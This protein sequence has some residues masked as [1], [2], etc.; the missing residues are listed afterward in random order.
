MKGSLF[1]NIS[2]KIIR[3]LKKTFYYFCFIFTIK[4]NR[5]LCDNFCGNSFNDNPRYIVEA[6]LK[7][8]KKTDIYWALNKKTFNTYLPSKVK[9]VKYNSFKYFY[10]LATSKVWVDN[11]RMPFRIKKRTGQFYIQTWHGGFG[12]KRME[13]DLEKNF[14]SNYIRAAKF[15]SKNIDLLLTN[16]KWQQKYLKKCFY[17]DGEIMISGYPRCDSLFD[18]TRFDSIRNKVY[19][20]LNISKDTKVLLYAPTFRDD[21]DTKCYDIDYDRLI[22]NLEKKYSGDWKILIR[23]HPNISNLDQI[24]D[25]KNIINVTNYPVLNDLM[26]SSDILISDYSSLVFEYGYLSRPIILYVPDVLKYEKE[27]GLLFNFVDLPFPYAMNNDE[28]E[29]IIASYPD[30]D[31]IGNLKKFYKENGLKEDGHASE[32]VA[33]IIL[34]KISE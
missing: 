19:K 3:M 14:D 5:V 26:I 27:R 12:F 31:Y 33:K 34:E 20:E 8:N 16:S 6:L 25:N 10:I 15:D 32:R 30:K 21:Y 9:K 17:Y 29:K 4:K 13:K 18:K 24:F 22:S 28:L 2:Q 11:V 23:M 7:I 1:K